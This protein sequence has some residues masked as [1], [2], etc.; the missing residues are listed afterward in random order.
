[1]GWTVA[2][3]TTSEYGTQKTLGE[4]AP[5]PTP[6]LFLVSVLLC[7]PS[8]QRQKSLSIEDLRNAGRCAGLSLFPLLTPPSLCKVQVLLLRKPPSPCSRTSSRV[9]TNQVNSVRN[10]HGPV[11]YVTFPFPPIRLLLRYRGKLQQGGMGNRGGRYASYVGL[12]NNDFSPPPPPL[13]QA[14]SGGGM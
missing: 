14:S 9:R 7:Y 8:L 4:D 3:E 11:A 6:P 13:L 2:G 12:E 1:V 10:A 5:P